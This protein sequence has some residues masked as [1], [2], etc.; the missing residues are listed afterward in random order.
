M[1]AGIP[2]IHVVGAAILNGQRCLVAQRGK[3]MSLPL[4][5]EFPG[6]KVRG[7]EDSSAALR[8]EISEEFG[9]E[10]EVHELVGQGT[11][12]VR[13]REIWL[14]VYRAELVSKSLVAREHTAVRWV[15]SEQIRH[16]DWAEADLPVVPNVQELI[17]R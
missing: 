13:G 2:T 9:A 12:V 8:R 15:G 3:E 17:S 10:I 5:W 11:S 7:G 6:G 16:L 4:K 14:E 1:A